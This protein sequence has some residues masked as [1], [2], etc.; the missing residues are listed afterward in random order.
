[1]VSSPLK[2]G[3]CVCVHWDLRCEHLRENS[4]T[5]AHH[6]EFTG[7]C[8]SSG[9][10]MGPAAAQIDSTRRTRQTVSRDRSSEGNRFSSG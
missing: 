9:G 7:G 6:L 8:R 10:R 4:W 3:D 2:L 5:K 1:M